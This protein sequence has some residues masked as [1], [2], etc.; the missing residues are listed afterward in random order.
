MQ[1]LHKHVDDLLINGDVMQ[2]L[3]IVEIDA[4]SGAALKTGGQL[5]AAG[6]MAAGAGMVGALLGAA[7]GPV[8]SAGLAVTFA[9]GGWKFVEYICGDDKAN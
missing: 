8:G 5:A 6:I 2:E 3:S 4:V 7:G 9:R 1:F